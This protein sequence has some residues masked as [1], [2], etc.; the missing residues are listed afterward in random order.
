MSCDGSD[1][2]GKRAA[3]LSG[4]EKSRQCRHKLAGEVF[5]GFA[6]PLTFGL[7]ACNAARS[8]FDAAGT[9]GG[10]AL[11]A[12]GIDPGLLV[13]TGGAAFE[14]LL[15]PKVSADFLGGGG[16]VLCRVG[17][18]IAAGSSFTVPDRDGSEGGGITVGRAGGGGVVP[19]C[20]GCTL[21][22]DL[23]DFRGNFEPATALLYFLWSAAFS[24]WVRLGG[25]GGRVEGS[26]VGAL[27][28]NLSDCDV[29]DVPLETADTPD[30]AV[31]TE[32]MDSFDVLRLSA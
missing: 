20:L 18:A 32:L 19:T 29:T 23:T 16:S 30:L 2:R 15:S 3:W 31:A 7:E 17:G 13:G 4:P 27:I 25:R 6:A 21:G 1:S 12:W 5:C 8:G 10:A 9:G 22:V 14:A 26:Y 24:S 28:E 11:S